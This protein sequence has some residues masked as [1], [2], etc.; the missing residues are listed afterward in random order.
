VSTKTIV[1]DTKTIDPT[2][3]KLARG[4]FI[5]EVCRSRAASA[6]VSSPAG[7]T[8][9]CYE[10]FGSALDQAVQV[11]K[12]GRASKRRGPAYRNRGD[13]VEINSIPTA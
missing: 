11:H 8:R 3:D 1:R 7:T 6:L 4:E 12:K 10:D 2:G 5:C 9:V 13:S